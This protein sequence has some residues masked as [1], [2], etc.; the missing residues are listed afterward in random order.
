MTYSEVYRGIDLTYYGN[1][2]QVEHD[3]VVHPGANPSNIRLQF[4]GARNVDV[5]HAG[6]LT[7]GLDGSAVTLRRPRAYQTIAGVRREVLAKFVVINGYAGFRLGSYDRTQVLIIDPTLDYSTFL[8]DASV[9]VTGIAVDGTGS[10]YVTGEA[11][12]AFPATTNPATCSSCVTATNKLAVYVTKINPAGTAVVYST[13]IGGSH[14]GYPGGTMGSNDQSTALTVDGNGN[15]IV[16]GWT[17][18]ADFPLKNPIPSGVASYEDGFVTSLTPDGS[19]LNFSSRLGGSSSVSTSATVYPQS[20]ATD[21]NG[22]VYVAGSSQSPYLPTTP[23]ALQAFLPSYS[24][25]GAFLLKLA[26]A[27]ALTYGAIVGEIGSAS[28]T[29]GPTGLAV[30]GAGIVYMSGTVGSSLTTGLVTWPTTAGAYQTALISPS[31]NAPFV[32]RISADGSTILSSTLMGTGNVTSMALTPTHDVLIAGTAGYNFPVTSDAY[33]SSVSTS[34]G[35]ATTL[36][37]QGFFAKVSE[38]GTQLLYSSAFG[39]G[40]SFLTIDGIGEDP[41]GNVW[42]AGTTNGGLPTLVHPLQSVSTNQFSGIG[43]IAE[44]DP[45][46]HNLLFSSYVNSATG[47]SQVD[48]LAID[49]SG[50]VHVVGIAS[51]TFPTTPGAAVQTVTPPPPNYTYD[52]GFAALIDGTKPGPSICFANVSYVSTQVGTTA[53]SSFNI[54]NCGDGPLTI[55]S[56]QLTS[57]VFAFASANVCTGTLAAGASCTLAY[58]FTPKV[59]GNASASVLITSDAPMAANTEVLSATGTTPVVSLPSSNSFSFAPMVLGAAAQKGSIL[60]GNKGTSPLVIDTS[61]TTITGPFSVVSTTCGNPVN[62]SVYCSYVFSFNPTVAG[63][64]TGALTIYTNDPVTPTVTVSI[65]GSALASYPV[66]TITGLTV[67]TL[68]L[69][70]GPANIT[71]NGTNFFPA[72]TVFINGASYPIKSQGS[73]GIVVTVDPATLGVMG[74]FPVQVVNPA[75]GGGSNLATLTTFHLIN[76]TATSVVYEPNSKMLYVAIPATSSSNPNT[77][78]PINPITGVSGT[79]IPVGVNPNRLAVSDDGHY[80]YV[81]FYYT[82]SSTGSLQRIDLT[83]GSV[84]RTFTLPGSSDGIIDMHVVPGSPQLLVAAVGQ[85][86]SPSENGVALFNDSGV[87]QYI[88]NDYADKNYTLDNFTFTSGPTYY[89]Y[90][91]GG[92]FFNSASVS[93]SGIVLI[94]RGGFSCC[95]QA[96]GSIM[97]SDGT[98]LYTNSGEVWDPTAQKLLGRYDSNLFYEA[99]IVADATAKRT[100]I[101]EGQYQPS[102]GYAYPAVISYDP[103]TFTLAGAIYFNL[104]TSPTS[105]ARWGTDGFAFLTGLTATGSFTNPNTESQLVLFRSSLA[106]PG[107]PTTATVTSLSPASVAAGSPALTLIVNG[108]GFGADSTVLWNGVI[109]ATTF[110]STSQLSATISAADLAVSGAAQVSVSGY[111]TVSPTVP[112]VV[113]GPAVTL[114]ATTITFSLQPVATASLTQTVT[115]GNTGTLPLTGLSIGLTG[116]DVGSFVASSACGN[117]LAPGGSCTVSVV[118][119][120]ATAGSKQAVLQIT[121]NAFDNPQTVALNGT[122]ASPSLSLS[123]QSLSFGQLPVGANTQQVLTLQNSSTVLLAN[124]VAGVTGQNASEFTEASNCGSSLAAGGTCTVS[125][126]FAPSVTGNKNATLT[127]SGTGVAPQTVVLSG[128]STTPDF[129][130]PAPLGSAAATV[131]AGQPAMFSLNVSQYGA[132]TGTVSMSCTNLPV[133][134]SCTFT[135]ASFTVGSTSTPVTLS[136]STE[137]TVVGAIRSGPEVPGWP[138]ISPNWR[139][140]LPFLQYRGPYAFVGVRCICFSG[141]WGCSRACACS[142][143]AAVATTTPIPHGRAFRRQLRAPMP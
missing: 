110:V 63:T 9:Y 136:I 32:T 135:P 120:P 133:Y 54:V 66:P 40:S 47:F 27:G 81:G 102:N 18:S 79:P 80:L 22:N 38:D 143:D 61:R 86:A 97:V 127:I 12:V 132:F 5:T 124:V 62:P 33:N 11:A 91:I 26:P 77:I 103:A 10:T 57:D 14:T 13:F 112:F 71:I 119:N 82:Y 65:T 4:S 51:Q 43:Y 24:D 117:S 89:G 48:G 29:T 122:A 59:A 37:A 84:D 19:S 36:G 17:S 46:M 23:G 115:V 64:T 125:V 74:D 113:G 105:L 30:D 137:Q 92:S 50:L 16:I 78:L 60:I 88:G 45:A 114:S 8:G 76:L 126:T 1:G 44:F 70:S 98:L 83:T 85:T 42:F 95:D 90:P 73:T 96:S 68:S 49:S 94:S 101:L 52:Y 56:M 139:P 67:P 121:D 130:L 100:F 93:A 128:A 106:T 53:Q 131:P 118:F 6:D 25:S 129:V 28:G 34:I 111:G 123:S 20:L 107:A 116:S 35:G 2:S 69:D 55:S 21:L 39:P 75:P 140:Y 109:R 108:S 141:C 58:T 138:T 87:V 142:T 3:F 31:Q 41:S 15:A 99:G 72:S 7:I 134:A 104:S